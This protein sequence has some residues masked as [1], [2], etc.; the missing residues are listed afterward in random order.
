MARRSLPIAG[1]VNP[2]SVWESSTKVLTKDLRRPVARA[3]A[4]EAAADA[5]AWFD[6]LTSAVAESVPPD[7]P[8]A[9]KPGCAHC[10]SLK[11]VVAAPEAIR[12][13]DWLRAT[14]DDGALANL[15]AHVEATDDTTRGMTV[16][17][18]MQARVPCPLLAKDRCMA[19]AVR[20]LSCRGA[21]SYDA[22][23]CRQSLEHPERRAA[24]RCYGPQ[25]AIGDALRAGVS[26]AAAANQLDGTMLELISALRTLLARPQA[27]DEW[28]AGRRDALTAARDREFA[29]LVKAGKGS[30]R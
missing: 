21:N 9:C 13:V 27:G 16:A 4:S 7:R 18:R 6:E 3:R 8:I 11:V 19:H 1:N 24:F 26:T 28:G 14:L 23:A 2:R 20:P 25:V 10:C 30:P 12:L 29:E 15:R 22:E 17:Q 5:A